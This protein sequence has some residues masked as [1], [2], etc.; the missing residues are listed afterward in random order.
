[1]YQLIIQGR[2]QI[3]TWYFSKTS[4]YFWVTQHQS[5]FLQYC[6]N[7]AILPKNFPSR[8]YNIKTT[9][10]QPILIIIIEVIIKH[11][12]DHSKHSQYREPHIGTSHVQ[13]ENQNPNTN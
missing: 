2:L 3:P 7:E 1:M 12:N 4:Y 9:K 13:M 11:I 8:N 5:A 10:P 6:A